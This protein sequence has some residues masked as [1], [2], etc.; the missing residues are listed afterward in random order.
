MLVVI[1]FIEVVAVGLALALRMNSQEEPVVVE[2]VVTE[3]LPMRS[4]AASPLAAMTTAIATAMTM[5]MATTIKPMTALAVM[6]L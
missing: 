4:P 5:M 3:Y 2:R 1:A 6:T